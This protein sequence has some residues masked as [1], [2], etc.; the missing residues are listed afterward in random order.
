MSPWLIVI[1]YIAVVLI[2][3]AFN[4]GAHMNDDE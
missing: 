1:A 2:I 3:V 4:H